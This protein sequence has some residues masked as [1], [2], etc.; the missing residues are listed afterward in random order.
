MGTSLIRNCLLLGPTMVLGEVQFL[1]SGTP[2]EA[3][4]CRGTSLMRN[5][6]RLGGTYRRIMP[7]ALWR[8]YGGGL[9][10]MIEVPL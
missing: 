1:M 10:L 3:V 9:F 5:S 2:V 4:L 8:P 7:R 6:G